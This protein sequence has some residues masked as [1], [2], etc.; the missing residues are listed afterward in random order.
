M[1][2]KKQKRVRGSILEI[3]L[4]N[5]MY[6][7]AQDLDV[8]ILFFDIYL[9]SPIND[10]KVLMNKQPLF[11]L[12]VYNDVITQGKW[13][14]VGSLPIKSEYENVP[15]KFIQDSI[16][17]SNFELY[18]PNT[19]EILSATKEQCEGLECAA[20]WESEHVEDRIKDYYSG[21]VNQW[22]EQLKII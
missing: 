12:G 19:G 2:L 6:A 14:K 8:D 7:Y 17:P 13:L 5:G 11:F 22:V 21:R 20:V 18:N 9:A 3:K 10:I 1:V 15:L 4:D 16:N